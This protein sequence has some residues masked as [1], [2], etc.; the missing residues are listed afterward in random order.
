MVEI[1]NYMEYCVKDM[2]SQVLKTMDICKCERCKMDILAHALNHLPPKYVV[3]RTGT[4]YAKLASMYN[5]F[6]S[7]VIVA[8]TNAAKVVGKSPRHDG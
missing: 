2:L 6:D 5:Q 3:T 7:D 4:I 1:K 8:I